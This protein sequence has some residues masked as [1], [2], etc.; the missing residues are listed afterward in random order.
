MKGSLVVDVDN[1]VIFIV[2][3]M[4]VECLQRN[5]FIGTFIVSKLLAVHIQWAEVGVVV[6]NY[7]VVEHC[8]LVV[9]GIRQLPKLFMDNLYRHTG[10]YGRYEGVQE[11]G[12]LWLGARAEGRTW[13]LLLL[14]TGC[15]LRDWRPYYCRSMV[16]SF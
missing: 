13:V 9:S 12:C 3:A 4:I 8:V 2:N 16:V 15:I 1:I 10:V 7:I 5:F 11:D 6:A 14:G